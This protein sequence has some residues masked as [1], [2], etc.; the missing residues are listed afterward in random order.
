MS[1][2]RYSLPGWYAAIIAC[3]MSL[4]GAFGDPAVATGLGATLVA[5]YPFVRAKTRGDFDPFELIYG[6]FAYTIFTMLLRGWLD[7]HFGGPILSP[8]YDIH[9]PG[10]RILM[11]WV[12]S[13]TGLF[14]LCF[15]IGYYGHMGPRLAAA[16]PRLRSGPL[17]PLA[18][19]L[20]VAGS[21][22]VSLPAAVLLR[23]RLGA[24]ISEGG[25]FAA[26]RAGGVSGIS[27]LLRF[28]L[29]GAYL[30]LL[31]AA[32]RRPKLPL[33]IA[34]AY[35]LMISLVVF[36]LF[37]TKI[38]VANTLLVV[39]GA[40]HYLRSPI[41]VPKL[42]L[43]VACG[44]FLLP[45][46][47][48]YRRGLSVV[49]IFGLI[50]SLPSRP[51]LLVAG[52]FQRSFGADSFLVVID[53]IAHKMPL[54]GGRTF[55]GL[56]W[57]WVPREFWSEKPRTYAIEFWDSYL[58]Q[59]DYFP[60]FVSASPTMIGELYLNFW[61]PGLVIGGL[62]A[63]VG[64]RVIY[65][66]YRRSPKSETTTV[67]YLLTLAVLVKMVEA[68]IADHLQELMVNLGS[69]V[70]VLLA[71]HL[72]VIAVGSRLVPVPDVLRE[73]EGNARRL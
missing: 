34:M 32:R 29:V 31:R 41:R 14:L 35:A 63:G 15:M 5:L 39:L 64:Y 25:Y 45:V 60:Q 57:W 40:V 72:V 69:C 62:V 19:G 4:G 43:T 3:A 21:V 7:L 33:V 13:Y 47:T 17:P 10:F 70:V 67:L 38:L 2:G 30:A 49:E 52:L 23:A 51:E 36:T 20:A 27:F 55:G 66:W 1:T 54:E 8:R 46:L 44:L 16:L 11:A 56:L 73:A 28:A 18:V 59:S 24:A 12:F 50:R 37:P 65:D 42:A 22:A 68:P 48:A 26:S 6:F 58:H 61:W 9:S 71:I 53:G